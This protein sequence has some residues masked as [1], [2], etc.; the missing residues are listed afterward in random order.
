[1]LKCTLNKGTIMNNKSKKKVNIICTSKECPFNQLMESN[2]VKTLVDVTSKNIP[3]MKN[4]VLREDEKE[5]KIAF[6][7]ILELAI[8]EYNKKYKKEV[9]M[10]NRI[11]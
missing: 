3:I 10:I 1:M 8:N 9:T 5:T 7:E 6:I 11:K 4:A 2:F